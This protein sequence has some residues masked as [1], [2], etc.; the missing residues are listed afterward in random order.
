MVSGWKLTKKELFMRKSS[1]ITVFMLAVTIIAVFGVAQSQAGFPAPPGVPGI[2]VPSV[3]IQVNGYLP[4]PPGV[5]VYSVD[6]R[7]YYMDG[8]RH[9]RRVYLE[10][11]RKH[12]KKYKK[13]K[14]YDKEYDKRSRKLDKEYDK[15]SKKFDKGHGK[16]KH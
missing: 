4:A 5:R 3:N 8:N 7:P 11:D 6:D 14:K 2:L 16:D 9:D 12:D 10:K 15:E 13:N 1:F